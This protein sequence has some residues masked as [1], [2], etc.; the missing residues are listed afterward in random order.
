[1]KILLSRGVIQIS[2]LIDIHYTLHKAV[3]APGI[4]GGDALRLPSTRSESTMIEVLNPKTQ[5]EVDMVIDLYSEASP[6]QP[7][8]L[9][10]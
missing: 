5:D 3:S 2:A 7:C 4:P 8:V 10:D 6:G 9:K 1:V